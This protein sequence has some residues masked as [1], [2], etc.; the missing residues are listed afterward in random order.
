P[1]ASADHLHLPSMTWGPVEVVSPRLVTLFSFD[2]E[3]AAPLSQDEGLE[4]EALSLGTVTV[5]VRTRGAGETAK[6]LRD[7]ALCRGCV[8]TG[9]AFGL[10]SAAG[11]A[12]FTVFELT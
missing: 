3:V 4:W 7:H 5:E 2:P 11:S 8:Y 12:E 1:A 6:L 10:D 9:G